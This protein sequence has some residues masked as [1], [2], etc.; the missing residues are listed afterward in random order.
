MHFSFYLKYV[1]LQYE[2]WSL[3]RIVGLNFGLPVQIEEFMNIQL[4]GFR[5]ANHVLSEF[6]LADLPFMNPYD[7]ISL[8][9]I[10]VKYVK[11][12]ETIYENLK[13]L[14]KCYILEIAKIEAEISYVMKKTLI[15]KP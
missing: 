12:Y 13:R 6:T 14:I 7:W 10:V 5:G 1:K 8:F 11:K 9:S 2:S 15:L 4:K 3:K